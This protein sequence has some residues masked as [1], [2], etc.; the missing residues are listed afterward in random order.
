MCSFGAIR[1]RIS[2]PRSLGSWCIK[3]TDESV[4]R[5]DSSVPL[6]HPWSEWSNGSLILI[7]ITPEER[8]LRIKTPPPPILKNCHIMWL[9]AWG[10]LVV[11]VVVKQCYAICLQVDQ[12]LSIFWYILCIQYSR[13]GCAVANI[14]QGCQ[15]YDICIVISKDTQSWSCPLQSYSIKSQ[16]AQSHE[17]WNNYSWRLNS[18]KLAKNPIEKNESLEQAI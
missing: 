8:T 12:R 2:D 17:K 4:T 15:K 7:Q 5:V 10:I 3:G 6:M 18:A 1:I 13:T 16:Q 14:L 11:V 9:H